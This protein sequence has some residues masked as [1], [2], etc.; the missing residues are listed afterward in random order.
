MTDKPGKLGELTAE[1]KKLLALKLRMQKAKAEAEPMA[2]R[3]GGV[4]PLSFAQAR[5]WLLD[6]LAPG[7][8]AYNMPA[9][10][11]LRGPLDAAVLERVLD[12]IV[13]RHE[14]LRT[15]VEERGGEPVQVVSPHRPFHLPVEDLGPTPDAERDD[16]FRR[17][18]AAEAGRPFRLDQGPLFR[19]RLVRAA[20]D[21]HLFLW[22]LHHVVSD[23]WSTMIFLG[24]LAAIYDALSRGLP[25]P[26]APLPV[27]YGDYAARQRERLSGARLQAEVDWWKTRLAGAPALLELPTDHP[28]PPV[29]SDRGATLSFTLP[30]G[31]APRVDELARREEAT[32]FMVLLAA[33]QV[34]LSRWSG[35]D[36]VV[37]GTPIANR[38]TPAVEGLIGFFANTLALRGDLSGEPTFRDVVRR[39]RE[40][41]LGAYDHQDVPFEKLVEELNPERSLS[42]TPLFQVVFSLQNLAAAGPSSGGTRIGQ[43]ELTLV[44]RERLSSRFDLTLTLTQASDELIGGIEYSTDLFDPA[45]AQRLSDH[46]AALLGAALARPDA[47]ASALPLMDADERRRVLHAWNRTAA[48][49][50]TEPFHRLFEAQA[51]RTPDAR[52]I[53]FAGGETL[54]Y[55]EV[56]HRSN[57]LARHLRALGVALESTVAVSLD[58]SPEL[59]VA[60]LAIMKAG[61]AFLPVDPR[62][63]R[64]RRAYMLEDAGAR[65]VLTSSDLVPDLPDSSARVVSIDAER[66]A[67]ASHSSEALAIDVDPDN[68]AYVIYT[69]GSTGRPKG[70]VV[71][72]RGIGNLAAAQ[73]A[74]FG[75]DADSRILQFAS[76]SFDAAVAEIAQTLLSGATLVMADADRLMPGPGLASLLIEEEVT[77]ATLPPSA[78]A[79]MPGAEFP[80]LKTI[81][82]AG[83]AIGA[84]VARKWAQGRRF[85]N[86]YGPT[87]TTVC[88][89][90]AVDPPTDD[91]PPIGLPIQ[92]LRA[93]VLD[94]A[95]EPVPVGVPGELYVGGVGVARGYLN[96]PAMTAERF[97]PDPFGGDTGARLYRTG[98]RVRRRADGQ[99]EFLGRADQQV[100]VRGFR[101]EPGEIEAALREHPSVRDAVVVARG[102]A[103]GGARLVAYVV[104]VDGTAVAEDELRERLGERLPA[105]MVPSVFVA[106]DAIPTLPNGKV[107]RRALPEP[108]WTDR[109]QY[110]APRNPV[111]ETL[112]AIWAEVLRVDRIGIDDNFFQAGGHSLL[113]TRMVARVREAL[114]V[115]LPLR[116]IFEAPTIRALAGR[117]GGEGEGGLTI[118]PIVPT[119]RS[120]PIPLTFAQERLWAVE[121]ED[122]G[123]STFTMG[124][125]LRLGGA[126]DAAALERAVAE[127]VRRHEALRTTIRVVDGEATQ[128]V[129]PFAGFRLETDDLSALD[130]SARDAAF[131]RIAAAVTRGPYDLTVGPLFRA[132]LVR[133]AADDHVLLLG[134]H[135][136]VSDGWSVSLITSEVARAYAAFSRG[137]PSPLPELPVQ[138]ADFAV[139]QRQWLTGEV[140]ERQLAYWREALRG[141][142]PVLEL[143]SDRPRPPVPSHRGGQVAAHV[144]RETIDRLAALGRA[145]GASLFM[146]LLAAFDLVL[147]RASGRDDIV[148]GTPMV[149][150][151]RPELEGVVGLFLS[152]LALR[153]DLSG[154]PTFRELLRRVR[155]TTLGAYAHQDL[156]F[157]RLLDDLRVE[158][159][160]AWAPVFQVLFNMYN[161]GDGGGGELPG[162]EVSGVET[163]VEMAAKF[164]LTL[165]VREIPEGGAVLNLVYATD[166]FDAPRMEAMLGAYLRV[167]DQVAAD[168]D[169]VIDTLSTRTADG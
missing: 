90:K 139:L 136:I 34:L 32:P 141:A 133:L 138:Y 71:P 22:T 21:D 119:D 65:V 150:R 63:P 107:D 132:R 14:T 146:T 80:A 48:P 67:I 17:L 86:A 151:A 56:D 113:A 40:V 4:F 38:T 143:P 78:L 19:A 122:P 76:L 72:H 157:D 6:R 11:R 128:H 148:V 2:A 115:E 29:R 98:D 62:Y 70:V 147:S 47:P 57:R 124:V 145:E 85:V 44:E 100:K 144:P 31:T 37:V 152:T 12:E 162:L 15:H 66:D 102:D 23:G 158:R 20:A 68:A 8:P 153:T 46:F 160:P 129:S 163:G 43:A 99:I 130:E 89:T 33:F 166:L 55:A 28:R 120:R 88:A 3:E 26:L 91:T 167:L 137:E 54:T 116:A 53:R 51:R 104:P 61:G 77:V 106:L 82:S 16:A 168:P 117:V 95:M 39:V 165:Y 5:L 118:P 1:Q 79:A 125:P 58:R 83:E 154:R 111:E 59:V 164:D 7:S 73:R 45:T 75:I 142:P 18:A 9:A 134:M 114:G 169:V 103:S 112:A 123:T 10:F 109:Q 42:H 35:Q 84:D 27:Q 93:Y 81:A 155:E 30:A 64:E 13:R 41:T 156:P 97:V 140:L 121:Q 25:S 131:R 69:S 92:N 60:L 50:S 126:L 135:H 101:V 74:A 36:D 87:E 94:A 161:F 110:V 96:R 127:L 149:G 108:A 24:E 49:H 105:H 159:S 52:A